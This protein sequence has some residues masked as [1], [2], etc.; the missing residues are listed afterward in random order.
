MPGPLILVVEDEALILAD[1]ESA[2]RDGGYDVI[3]AT[4]AEHAMRQLEGTEPPVGLITDIRL[5][6]E[7]PSGWDIAHRAR[8]LCPGIGVIYMSGDSGGDWASKGVP[9][10]IFIQKPFASAQVVTAISSVL[11][12]GS[13]LLAMAE[14]P[15]D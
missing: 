15:D 10:S 9:E 6:G 11:N 7:Q 5:G 13:R 1:I 8:E 2:L 14:K 4:M 12:S 3:S